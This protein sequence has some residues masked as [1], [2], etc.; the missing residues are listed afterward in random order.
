VSRSLIDFARSAVL[1]DVGAPGWLAAEA[2]G[3]DG[4][5]ALALVDTSL[6]GDPTCN[7]FA[8]AGMPEHERLGAL[9]S[10]WATRVRLAPFYCGRPTAAGRPCRCPVA[11]AGA[12]CHWHRRATD[13]ATT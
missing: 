7:P 8:S 9:P 13:G 3:P 5:T 11:A 2:V 4:D 12:A 6:R 1:C 10:H